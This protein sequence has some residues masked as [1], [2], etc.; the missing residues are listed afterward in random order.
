[1]IIRSLI[2]DNIAVP[3]AIKIAKMHASARG[4]FCPPPLLRKILTKQQNHFFFSRR[5]F[6]PGCLEATRKG[7]TS[8]NT[9]ADKKAIKDGTSNC[10]PLKIAHFS[11]VVK[12]RWFCSKFSPNLADWYECVTFS[13]KIGIRTVCMDLLS[14]LTAATSLPKP[15]LGASR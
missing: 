12:S 14:N 6:R 4:H 1:M 10:G 9:V 5:V 7:E 11:L 15:R 13:W 8:T 3:W 2:K